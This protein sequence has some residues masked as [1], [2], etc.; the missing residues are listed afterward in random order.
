MTIS[1]KNVDSTHPSEHQRKS[2][3]TLAGEFL[4]FLVMGGANTLVA[5]AIY[6]A[7][8]PLMRYEFA[9]T[10]G[11][12]VGIAMAYLI[13]TRYVFR[14]PRRKRSAIR[15][16]FVYVAQYLVSLIVLRVAIDGFGVP[17]WLGLGVAVIFTIPVTFALS[18]WVI[19][20]G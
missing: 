1:D 5:Y 19:R 3:P 12:A 16:P 4:R 14:Q 15:F 13:S 9:Y 20:A 7:L 6:L 18:R 17:P 11:Y 8:L 2:L 10:M